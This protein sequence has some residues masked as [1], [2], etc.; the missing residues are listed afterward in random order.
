MQRLLDALMAGRMGQQEHLVA[1]ILMV[2]HINA[3]SMEE[4]PVVETPRLAELAGLQLLQQP[5]A[6]RR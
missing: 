2:R 3:R 1:E 6:V 5:L 4:E